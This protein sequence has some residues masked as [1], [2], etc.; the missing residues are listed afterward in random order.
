M[1]SAYSRKKINLIQNYLNYQNDDSILKKISINTLLFLSKNFPLMRS[2]NIVCGDG[3]KG[4]HG[5]ALA[6]YN[7]NKS[8]KYNIY[9][10]KF[11][12]KNFIFSKMKQNILK[13]SNNYFFKLTKKT[14][15][16]GDLIIDA[17]IETSNIKKIQ[18][19]IK[20]TII[21]INKSKLIII[22]L[23][24]PS[25]INSNTGSILDIA[26]KANITLVFFALRKG[27]FTG[28]ALDYTGNIILKLENKKIYKKIKPS[29]YILPK[30]AIG[31]QLPKRLKDSHKG[32]Y[33]CVLVIGGDYGMGGAVRLS[34][35]ASLRIGAGLV[36]IA[37]RKEHANFIHNSLPEAIVYGISHCYE[38]K[39]LLKKATSIVLGPG[40]GKTIWARKI[41]QYILNNTSKKSIVI[42]ADALNILSDYKKIFFH[43]SKKW[44]LTP[45]PGEAGRLLKQPTFKIQIDRFKAV[46]NIQRK[47][48]CIVILKGAGTLIQTCKKKLYICYSGNPGMSSGG[49]G[50]VLSG[51]L[52]GL[53]AQKIPNQHASRIGVQLHSYIADIIAKKNG[54]RGLLAS[55]LFKLIHYYCN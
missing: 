54:E 33:G 15:F 2:I 42:D 50:D 55:D 1:K 18:G 11:P 24:T 17:L 7:N 38:L 29:V 49:M 10:T 27:L 46:K 47:Y 35:E 25:G 39:S 3:N 53:L 22:S 36:I 41:F 23:N 45:H 44:I 12:E 52:G 19:I 51:I 26:V 5:Y 30:N 16:C 4:M 43:S 13:S 40:L 31:K 37:T 34:S 28:S 9:Y 21:N 32:S 20:S 48:N 6:Y 14:Q 8:I